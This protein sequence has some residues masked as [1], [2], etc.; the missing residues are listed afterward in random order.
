MATKMRFPDQGVDLHWYHSKNGPPILKQ[1]GVSG[2]GMNTVFIGT[3][4]ILATGFGGRKLYPEEKFADYSAPAQT[5]SKSPGFYNEWFTA[6]RGGAPATCDFDYSGP[7]SETVLLGNVAFRAGQA[8]DW[9]AGT[10]EVTGSDRAAGLIR[11][12]FRTGWDI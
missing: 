2:K 7:L 10:L 6:I 4:G 3:D 1:K 12:E 8:F 5:I 11:T 9:D